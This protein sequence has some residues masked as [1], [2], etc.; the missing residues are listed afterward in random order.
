MKIISLIAAIATAASLAAPAHA[1]T[2]S[3]FVGQLHNYGIY[4]PHDY[5]AWLGKIVCERQRNGIDAGP[6][7]AAAFIADNLP[8][9][10]DRSRSWQF[11]ATA[12]AFYCPDRADFMHD[13]PVAVGSA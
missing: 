9:G 10:T 11:L 3:D 5:D 2:D 4:G 8:T 1:D 6:G 12:I 13:A 7:R